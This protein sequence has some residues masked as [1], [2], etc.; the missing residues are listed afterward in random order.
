MIPYTQV[1]GLFSF[2]LPEAYSNILFESFN[3]NDEVFQKLKKM[4]KIRL[5]QTF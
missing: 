5:Y 3:K 1:I 4:K 2:I